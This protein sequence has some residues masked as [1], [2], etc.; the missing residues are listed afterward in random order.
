MFFEDYRRF[1]EGKLT[2]ERAI[3]SLFTDLGSSFYAYMVM[4]QVAGRA[5]EADI[6]EKMRKKIFELRHKIFD[7]SFGEEDLR[8]VDRLAVEINT[9]YR[10]LQVSK[11]PEAIILQSPANNAYALFGIMSDYLKQNEGK[12]IS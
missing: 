12:K 7:K 3:E 2:Q 4:L 5:D 9:I 11:S 10:H 1:C 8:E 6:Y